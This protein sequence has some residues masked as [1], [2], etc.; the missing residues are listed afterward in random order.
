MCQV[1]LRREAWLKGRDGR[2][3]VGGGPLGPGGPRGAKGLRTQPQQPN[4]QGS[5]RPP[6]ACLPPGETRRKRRRRPKTP[7][8]PSLPPTSPPSLSLPPPSSPHGTREG[9]E[10]GANFVLRRRPPAG[11]GAGRLG[12]PSSTPGLPPRPGRRR[13]PPFPSPFPSPFPFPFPFLFGGAPGRRDC[14][15][16]PRD[17]MSTVATQGPP[18]GE[19]NPP[20]DSCT[21][22]ITLTVDIALTRARIGTAAAT[23]PPPPLARRDYPGSRA[24]G[25]GN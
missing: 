14:S 10:E 12:V 2:G 24:L 5:P 25:L 11:G 15:L 20:S 18:G 6:P 22:D 8:L 1:S 23:P 4:S 21:V 19:K 3:R 9:E 16:S 13:P 7:P 17:R